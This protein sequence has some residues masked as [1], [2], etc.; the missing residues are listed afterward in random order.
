MN[1]VLSL[2]TI[3]SF[4]HLL[5]EGKDKSLPGGGGGRVETREMSFAD[6]KS[7]TVSLDCN[8]T[9]YLLGLGF[10]DS[11]KMSTSSWP[12]PVRVTLGGPLELSS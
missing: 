7:R 6:F 12:H 10:Q 3:T 5:L 2:R 1:T 11:F 8:A 4:L 9:S